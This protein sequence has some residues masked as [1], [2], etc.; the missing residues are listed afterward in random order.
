M[1]EMVVSVDPGDTTGVALWNAEGELIWKR[2]MSLDDFI[3]W[4]DDPGQQLLNVTVVVCEDYTQRPKKMNRQG[5]KVKAAQGIGV[6]KAFAQKH[7]AKFVAQQPAILSVAALHTRTPH[8]S[9]QPDDV[10]AFLHGYFYFESVGVLK[11]LP[12]D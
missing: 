9:H 4:C 6:A 10:S 11:P 3:Y 12:L 2:K 7:K 5:N 8:R 1:P